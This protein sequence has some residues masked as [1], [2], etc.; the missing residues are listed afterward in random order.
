MGC[1]IHIF[2]EV[3]GHDRWYN[4]T[5]EVDVWG[6]YARDE[7]P[8][9]PLLDWVF[10]PGRNYGLFAL[11]AD[12]R[13]G[14][15]VAGVP[16]ARPVQP[17]KEP[18]GLPDDLSP[19]VQAVMEYH[20]AFRK[21][22][23]YH[24]C[25]YYTVKELEAHIEAADKSPG[26]KFYAW[27]TKEDWLKHRA[28]HGAPIVTSALLS[29]PLLTEEQAEALVGAGDEIPSD[30]LIA[31]TDRVEGT[32]RALADIVEASVMPFARLLVDGHGLDDENV[33]VVMAFDN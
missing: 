28:G 29:V 24:S 22:G 18:A 4:V 20:G 15:G 17:W 30:A 13:N 19:E 23:D 25:T 12:V 2:I 9:P 16:T 26:Q 14:I 8:C 32:Q 11:L 27:R 10:A 21:F 1:D 31:C 3:K 5:P 7:N 33:R 6:D